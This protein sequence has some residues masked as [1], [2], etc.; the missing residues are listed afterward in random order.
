MEQINILKVQE[1]LNGF[2]NENLYFHLETSNGAYSTLEEDENISIC[3]FIRNNK[4]QFDRG[5]ITG[6]GSYRVGLRLAEGWLYA[7][8][9]TDWEVTERQQL[10]LAGHDKEGR[11]L[12]ALELSR[13]PFHAIKSL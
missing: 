13:E 1:Y 7:E 4:I 2:I 3:T 11:V 10:L 5:V 6:E 9:L 12:I 8:G